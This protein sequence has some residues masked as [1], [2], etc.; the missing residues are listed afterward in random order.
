MKIYTNVTKYNLNMYQYIK[1]DINVILL[2]I[3]CS[4][5]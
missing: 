1:I 3:K 2:A 4:L 5:V